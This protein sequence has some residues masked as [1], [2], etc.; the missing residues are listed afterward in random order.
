MYPYLRTNMGLGMH[1][2]GSD[3]W[4]LAIL[5]PVSRS[6]FAAVRSVSKSLCYPNPRAIQGKNAMALSA[7][8]LPTSMVR[9]RACIA[10]APH[11]SEVTDTGLGE[12][13]V[14]RGTFVDRYCIFS[15]HPARSPLS[16]LAGVP[17]SLVPADY[18]GSR[19][20]S[21]SFMSKFSSWRLA[22]K[23]YESLLGAG[24]DPGRTTS[25]S[26]PVDHAAFR[27]LVLRLTLDRDAVTKR[28]ANTIHQLH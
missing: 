25:E 6:R 28:A 11:C 14:R 2:G 19:R 26:E 1:R 16:T 17:S 22:V 18:G 4:S 20:E 10:R 21:G 5:R 7:H 9:D 12:G 15:A 23:N 13:L 27:G 24:T 8:G 3:R